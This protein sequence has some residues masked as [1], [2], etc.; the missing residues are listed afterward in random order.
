[1]NS[2]QSSRRRFLKQG[3]MFAGLA[4]VGAIQP[5]SGQS[6]APSDA[7]SRGRGSGQPLRPDLNGH[8]NS[9]VQ[10]TD[11]PEAAILRDPWDGSP[12]RDAEGNIQADWTGTEEWKDYQKML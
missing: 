3:S 11:P 1:M 4:A 12:L 5:A 8:M 10:L 7:Q 2:K 6:S 9:P